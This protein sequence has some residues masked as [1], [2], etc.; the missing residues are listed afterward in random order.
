MA[1][2]FSDIVILLTCVPW[3]TTVSARFA[4]QPGSINQGKFATPRPLESFVESLG[5]RSFDAEHLKSTLAK[6]TEASTA[7]QACTAAQLLLGSDTVNTPPVKQTTVDG[8]W[9]VLCLY[10]RTETLD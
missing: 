7:S 6:D 5:L 8:S 10:T 4:P 2:T 3:L 9:F 1:L